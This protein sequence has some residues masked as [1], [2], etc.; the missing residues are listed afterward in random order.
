MKF[1]NDFTNLK[2]LG[3]HGAC[4]Y[5]DYWENVIKS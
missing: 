3:S 4:E 5:F 2:S 1:K